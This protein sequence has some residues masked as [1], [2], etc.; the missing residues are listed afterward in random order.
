MSASPSRLS[1]TLREGERV[2][3]LAGSTFVAVALLACASLFDGLAQGALWA[4]AL[5]LDMGGPYLFGSEGW[6]LVPATSP[7]ATG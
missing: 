5:F 3:G 6:K 7:S 4:L 1:A 2:L